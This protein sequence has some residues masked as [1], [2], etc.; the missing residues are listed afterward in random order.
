MGPPQNDTRGLALT[1][2]PGDTD[3]PQPEVTVGLHVPRT[4]TLRGRNQQRELEIPS[5]ERS[6]RKGRQ[7]GDK[8]HWNPRG[9][10]E[11]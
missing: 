8:A 11:H 7:Q 10:E 2:R 1:G 4:A 6:P 9:H 3:T 5:Q